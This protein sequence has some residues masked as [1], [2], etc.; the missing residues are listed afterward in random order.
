VCCNKGEV[1][2][3][4][5]SFFVRNKVDVMAGCDEVLVQGVVLPLPETVE[6]VAAAVVVD[7]S[8]DVPACTVIEMDAA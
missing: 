3:T 4:V 6:D 8:V 7:A 5:F 2:V 1:V